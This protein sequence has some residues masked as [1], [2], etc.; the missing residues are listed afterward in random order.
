MLFRSEDWR[1]DDK[2]PDYL[3]WCDQLYVA[4]PVDF[5]QELIPEEVG[6]IVADSFD[7]V[8]HRAAFAA[9]P[10]APARRRQQLIRFGRACAERLRR[11]TDPQ[12]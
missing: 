6:L 5:P 8:S 7:A 1:V 9:P 3:D 10:L 12:P 11:A 2:W 4:V